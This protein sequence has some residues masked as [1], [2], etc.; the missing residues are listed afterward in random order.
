MT[1]ELKKETKI[2]MTY[3]QALST[4]SLLALLVGGYVNLKTDVATLTEK[5]TANKE[6]IEETRAEMKAFIIDNKEDHKQIM[7]KLDKIY[8]RK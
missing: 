1:A 3:G 8:K 7:E 5:A 4:L 2:G 6:R